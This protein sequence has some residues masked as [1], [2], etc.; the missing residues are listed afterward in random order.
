[1]RTALGWLV[2]SSDI[3]AAIHLAASFWRFWARLG[4][5]SEGLS[6]VRRLLG[7]PS[8]TPPRLRIKLLAAAAMLSMRALHETSLRTAEE[9]LAEAL[10]LGREY[11]ACPELAH[12]LF[13]CGSVA[14]LRCQ[15]DTAT[16]FLKQA[17]E[18]CLATGWSNE[19]SCRVG[20]ASVAY[21]QGRFDE[22]REWIRAAQAGASVRGH[23]SG[24][25]LALRNLGAVCYQQGDFAAARTYILQSL[26]LI[27]DPLDRCTALVYLGWVAR[28]TGSQ[29]EA[30]D[31]FTKALTLARNAGDQRQTAY[32]LEAFAGLAAGA[33][34]P[35][36]ALRLAAAAS[37]LRERIGTPIFPVEG[38]TLERWLLPSRTTLGP[39]VAES[40]WAEGRTLSIEQACEDS[41]A[42]EV[43]CAL[44]NQSRPRASL[45]TRGQ[46]G[47]VCGSAG[48]QS[49]TIEGRSQ[50]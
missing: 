2:D 42:C 45:R 46:T 39:A 8:N 7:L 43:V 15:F 11:G 37:V 10:S 28:D 18:A 20:L 50:Q 24:F 6:W 13:M 3:E 48:R 22:A 16:A 49:V 38:A 17:L 40:I 35:A 21:A 14:R 25:G 29:M 5:V 9:F 19:T 32:C 34:Q 44:H 33:H 36:R 31:A 47:G 12:T 41:L 4:Y 23:G 1:V 26:E 30:R 27:D